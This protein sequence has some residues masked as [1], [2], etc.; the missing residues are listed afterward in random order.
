MFD[1]DG[2]GDHEPLG[3][4]QINLGEIISKGTPILD[5]KLRKKPAGKLV[6]RVE[7]VK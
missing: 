1:F 7:E 6:V 2:P 4:V 5:L 3:E